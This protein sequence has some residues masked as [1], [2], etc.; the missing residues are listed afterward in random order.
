[1]LWADLVLLAA[2]F[3]ATPTPRD[4]GRCP[5]RAA[6]AGGVDRVVRMQFDEFD[7]SDDEYDEAL[8]RY[9]ALGLFDDA[10]KKAGSLMSFEDDEEDDM[11]PEEM[12]ALSKKVLSNA[13]EASANNTKAAES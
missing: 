8:A 6:T 13:M 4:V 3:T 5:T 1:M 12:V 11:T 7:G 10:K 9:T 2:A